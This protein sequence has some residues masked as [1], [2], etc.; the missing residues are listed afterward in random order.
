MTNDVNIHHGFLAQITK[1]IEPQQQQHFSRKEQKLKLTQPYIPTDY[2]NQYKISLHSLE[3]VFMLLHDKPPVARQ[4][5]GGLVQLLHW[6]LLFFRTPV[7]VHTPHLF[8][9]SWHQLI[10]ITSDYWYI[11][12]LLL[13]CHF[14]QKQTN[15]SYLKL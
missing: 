3:N 10:K 15:Q 2:Y 5:S 12:N 14:I 1:R 6:Y 13:S 4:S 7:F 8:F 9:C 11:V